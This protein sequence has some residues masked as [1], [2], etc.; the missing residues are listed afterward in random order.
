MNHIHSIR[1]SYY[2]N[3]H[4]IYNTFI[5][6]SLTLFSCL[7]QIDYKLFSGASCFPGWIHTAPSRAAARTRASS[8][9]ASVPLELINLQLFSLLEFNQGAK[10][11]TCALKSSAIQCSFH[12]DS[13]YLGSTDQQG[14]GNGLER[15]RKRGREELA[16][17][18]WGADPL[19]GPDPVSIWCVSVACLRY[20]NTDTGTAY[21]RLWKCVRTTHL[22]SSSVTAHMVRLRSAYG[23]GMEIGADTQF[24]LAKT[25]FWLA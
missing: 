25:Y 2:T 17:V 14:A 16:A 24:V 23:T 5:S 18:R 4:R 11:K 12:H 8:I 13:R 21:T 19:P 6:S 7:L 1:D 20:I 15:Q 22:N 9:A 3:Q 10:T